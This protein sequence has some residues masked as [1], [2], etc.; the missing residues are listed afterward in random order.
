MTGMRDL[1]E[2]FPPDSDGAFPQY[3]PSYTSLVETL[4]FPILLEVNDK[5]YSG[6]SRML[7]A[8]GKR[9]G[10]LLFGWGSCSGCDAL[11]A[12]DSYEELEKLR[13]S[14][15]AGIT[16]FDDSRAALIWFA[17]HDWEA[18]CCFHEEEQ[19]DFVNQA[20]A[21]LTAQAGPA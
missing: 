1:R 5:G 20:T 7:L 9:R 15:A 6:D 18:D 16:W 10:Y 19:R 11:Q 12:C 21:L 17:T 14:L 2:A 3:E 4:G 8:D 13:A